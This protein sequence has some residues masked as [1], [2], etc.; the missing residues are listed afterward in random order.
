MNSLELDP[1]TNRTPP[2]S[3]ILA[4]SVMGS[5]DEMYDRDMEREPL[6]PQSPGDAL[7]DKARALERLA[8]DFIANAA[9]WDFPRRSSTASDA[10]AP[11]SPFSKQMRNTLDDIQEILRQAENEKSREQ[12]SS[13]MRRSRLPSLTEYP[14]PDPIHLQR[15]APSPHITAV[16]QGRSKSF[17]A[18]TAP[19]SPRMFIS[20]MTQPQDPNISPP[21]PNSRVRGARRVSSGMAGERSPMFSPDFETILAKSQDFWASPNSSSGELRRGTTGYLDPIGD[22]RIAWARIRDGMRA[23]A[24][25]SQGD[26]ICVLAGSHGAREVIKSSLLFR[27]LTNTEV[28]DGDAYTKLLKQSKPPHFKVVIA[29]ADLFA[30]MSTDGMR[31]SNDSEGLAE[32]LNP[33]IFDPRICTRYILLISCKY[34]RFGRYI[35]FAV[36]PIKGGQEDTVKVVF[37]ANNPVRRSSLAQSLLAC[38][39]DSP[40][41]SRS[42]KAER[43]G[44]HTQQDNPS[45]PPQASRGNLRILL[46]EDNLVNIEVTLH[47]P[48]IY[49]Y[50]FVLLFLRL[51]PLQTCLLILYQGSYKAT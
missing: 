50:T 9:S 42:R 36:P 24:L 39:V 38:V 46:C 15:E 8:K 37:C 13:G 25:S 2:G 18:A 41:D 29:E 28:M 43:D 32:V 22:S 45:T 49:L 33:A 10:S 6:V 34:H 23:S 21:I 17:T 1:E 4:Q 51:P 35:K 40:A 7:T 48:F 31:D 3:A 20:T 5:D 27:G 11:E 16:R 44:T 12:Q 26:S 14:S 30:R 47:S 19:F